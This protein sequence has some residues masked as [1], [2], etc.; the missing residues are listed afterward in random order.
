MSAIIPSP[1]A[2]DARDFAAALLGEL[3]RLRAENAALKAKPRQVAA[4]K[5]YRTRRRGRLWQA[6]RAKHRGKR[7]SP[8]EL[9]E[10]A[11]IAKRLLLDGVHWTRI[12]VVLGA[13]FGCS[14]RTV[15]VM[16]CRVR[17][18]LGIP[19]KRGPKRFR[20]EVDYGNCQSAN[21][22]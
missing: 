13:R 3:A 9:R 4:D 19:P 21:G 20:T 7:A 16:L 18:E 11:E 22:A 2:P 17:R 8:V 5:P 1:A 6:P 10:R 12:A 14:P 15:E